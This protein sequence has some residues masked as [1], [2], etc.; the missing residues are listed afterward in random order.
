MISKKHSRILMSTETR[1]PTLT[2]MIKKTSTWLWIG[3]IGRPQHPVTLRAPV[4]RASGTYS[5]IST[6]YF[7]PA[8]PG[9]GSVRQPATGAVV[10]AAVGAVVGAAV[11][12]V[13]AVGVMSSRRVLPVSWNYMVR[14]YQ[15]GITYLSQ[16]RI[17]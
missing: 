13:A 16:D 17:S 6:L 10:D 7:H 9:T 8:V 1:R 14:Y 5:P 2:L 3:N 4:S 11:V 12:V 15:W